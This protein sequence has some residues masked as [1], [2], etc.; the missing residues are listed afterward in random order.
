MKKTVLIYGI[1][2]FVGSNLAQLLKDDFRVVGTYYNTPVSI[3]GVT[4]VP[5]DVLKKE[6]VT[7]LTGW[8]KPDFAIYAVG[9]S[10]LKE[11]KLKPKLADAINTTGAINCCIASERYRSRF[12]FISSAFVLGGDDLL[13]KEGDTPFPITAYGGSLSATEYYVQRSCLNYLIFRCCS[14]YGRGFNPKHN[15]WFESIQGQFAKG[16]SVVADDFI[17]MGF[18]D[19][20]LLGKIIKTVLEMNIQNRLFQVSSRDYMT[21][22]DFAQKYAEIFKKDENLIQKAT[23]E[24]PVDTDKS[25]NK[26]DAKRINFYKLDTSNLEEFLSTK[27]PSVEE[28]LHITYKRSHL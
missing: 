10:S 6:Y 2:S 3:P 18:L 9:M 22:F 24:F 8:I 28:S 25:A 7:N 5:C 14:L 19:V 21:R 12:I 16:E 1:S 26:D 4:C 13:Y 15:T 11:C 17:Q 23:V 20:H 27:M